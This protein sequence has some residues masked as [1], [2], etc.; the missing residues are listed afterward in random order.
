MYD[1]HISNRAK[2]DL[3]RLDKTEI[4]AVLSDLGNISLLVLADSD[5]LNAIN[6]LVVAHRRRI[7]R[8]FQACRPDPHG[9][10]HCSGQQTERVPN[11]W[12]NACIH[13]SIRRPCTSAMRSSTASGK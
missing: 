13:E 9:R 6:F 3:K 5:T 8:C 4:H 12:P 2:K 7:C 1:L 11:R 10:M